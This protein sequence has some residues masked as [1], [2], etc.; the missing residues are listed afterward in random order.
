MPHISSLDGLRGLA[1]AGVLLFHTGHLPG[2]FLGVDLFF[3]LSGY[4]ITAL[5][6]RELATTGTVSP[7]AQADLGAVAALWTGFTPAA[8][9]T[10]ANTGWSADR[11]F[12]GC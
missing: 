12:I 10:W 7:S 4:L 11:R 6:L 9:E 1:V 8:P 5:L 2:G 3:A